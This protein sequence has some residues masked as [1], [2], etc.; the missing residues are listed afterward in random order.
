MYKLILIALLVTLTASIYAQTT[1]EEY[2]Y[3]TKGYKEDIAKGRGLKK[4]YELKHINCFFSNQTYVDVRAF[5]RLKDSK[6]EKAAY[7]I[8]YKSPDLDSEYYCSPS[9]KSDTAV[10]DKYWK[11]LNEFNPT[12]A[13]KKSFITDAV[14]SI[15]HWSKNV[16]D[17]SEKYVKEPIFPGSLKGW[18]RYLERNLNSSLP[19][20]N[21][22]P[23]GKYTVTVDY[24]MDKNGMI[25]NAFA[26]NNPG[27][28]TAE[29]A[30]RVIKKA[31]KY[32]PAIRDGH[33]VVYDGKQIIT[34]VLSDG[35]KINSLETDGDYVNSRAKDYTIW[36]KYV[37]DNF[38]TNVPI[39]NGA[40]SGQY[41]VNVYFC[42]DSLG[43]ICEAKAFEYNDR[44]YG[45]AEE[46]IR[47][48]SNSP[49]W[50]P[51]KKNGKAVKSWS[52]YKIRFSI[53][54]AK[55]SLY[56]TE[57]EYTSVQLVPEF[58]GGPVAWNKYLEKNLNTS[59]PYEKGAA[60]GKY[61]VIVSFLVD[62]YGFIS[63]I[64]ADPSPYGTSE[65]AIRIIENGPNWKPAVQ[66]GHNVA[67]RVKQPITFIVK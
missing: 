37:Q 39:I 55:D 3:L 15:V 53:S 1:N 50:I 24:T 21:G 20:E 57:T 6:K 66:N 36:K 5:Y 35:K 26:E 8:V 12:V 13:D 63:E 28:G 40:P 61:T 22:A 34:F 48:I 62:K 59:L 9:P 43:D 11:Q 27:Y 47:V 41:S 56:H 18:Q 23:S 7:M 32:F 38:N 64:Q 45:M 29:E 4:G 65:E 10:V 49:D 17:T 58:R 46:G 14:N 51:A 52:N 54:N 31:P 2:D 67:Y 16:N 33:P 60:S 30:V 25:T 42:I 44:G 19:A